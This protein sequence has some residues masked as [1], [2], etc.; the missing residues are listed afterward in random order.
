VPN[1]CYPPYYNRTKSCSVVTGA[2]SL[3]TILV[4]L[5]PAQT[6]AKTG[7]ELSPKFTAT[8][9]TKVSGTLVNHDGIT[10]IAMKTIFVA[11]YSALALRNTNMVGS[12][13]ASDGTIHAKNYPK[14]YNDRQPQSASVSSACLPPKTPYL[15]YTCSNSKGEFSLQFPSNA[16]QAYQLSVSGYALRLKIDTTRIHAT[17]GIVRVEETV[18]PQ[19]EPIAIVSIVLPSLTNHLNTGNSKVTSYLLD[20]DILSAYGIDSTDSNIAYHSSFMLNAEGISIFDVARF[21]TILVKGSWQELSTH[22]DQNTLKLMLDYVKNGGRLLI[23][24]NKVDFPQDSKKLS[25]I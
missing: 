5:L 24:D 14:F 19:T 9:V 20:S 6:R 8:L 22:I 3:L 12:R 15:G 2:I 4:L 18:T 11:D 1:N 16:T 17:L 7:A 25:F 23:K 10:P 21:S 13:R